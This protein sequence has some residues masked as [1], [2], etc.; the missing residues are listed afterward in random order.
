MGTWRRPSWTAIV[1]PTI[2]GKIVESRDHVRRTSRRPPVFIAM[3][4][5]MSLAS[6]KGPFFRLRLISLCA[7]PHDELVCRLAMASLL[8]HRDLA[9]LGLRL[10]ADRRL[11]LA[12]AVGVVARIHRRP[13][14]RGTEAHVA[15]S[16]SFTNA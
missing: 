16:A 12:S 7:L 13:A 14:H 8:A 4:R 1:W 11:A 3:T 10:A 9:P 6:T 2:S 15:R 5:F